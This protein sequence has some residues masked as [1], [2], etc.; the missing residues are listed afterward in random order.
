MYIKL[1]KKYNVERLLYNQSLQTLVTQIRDNSSRFYIARIYYR[2]I[3]EDQYH[4]IRHF[5][6]P[7]YSYESPI[8]SG[9]APTIYFNVEER[10][11]KNETNLAGNWIETRSFD[12]NTKK[13][14]RIFNTSNFILKEN[15]DRAWI[16]DLI[17]VA[18]DDGI[19]CKVAFERHYI[20]G[21]GHVDYYL[22]KLILKTLQ[23]KRLTLLKHVFL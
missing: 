15:E 13:I 7:N 12:L 4:E 5:S 2:N 23:I 20:D 17:G 21:T 14:Q 1:P 8:V 6:E 18:S 3:K 22:C 19:F 11:I 10:K 16:S 9:S